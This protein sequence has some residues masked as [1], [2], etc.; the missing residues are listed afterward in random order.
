V[1]QIYG[2]LIRKRL[3]RGGDAAQRRQFRAAAAAAAAD[4][5]AE[6]D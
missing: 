2:T 5:G 3:S 1:V 4:S 6:A